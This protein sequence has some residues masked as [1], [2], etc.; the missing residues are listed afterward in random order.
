MD[1]I[2]DSYDGKNIC[3]PFQDNG[4]L[5]CKIF[6]NEG[7]VLSDLNLNIEFDIDKNSIPIT[8]L[9]MPMVTVAF[10]KDD[11]LYV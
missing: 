6:T 11:F 8:G 7:K 3:V 4:V 2:E 1:Q 10:I 5:Q 9:F